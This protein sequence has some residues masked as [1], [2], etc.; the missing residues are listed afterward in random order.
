MIWWLV[1]ELRLNLTK[2]LEGGGQDWPQWEPL[3]YLML[4]VIFPQVYLDVTDRQHCIC[5]RCTTDDF[6]I[7]YTLWNNYNK[8]G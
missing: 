5:L 7:F 4:V 1:V 2:L 8:V 6:D 3:S